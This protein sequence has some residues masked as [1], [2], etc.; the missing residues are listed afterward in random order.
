MGEFEERRRS[1]RVRIAHHGM[2]VATTQRV[3]VLDISLGGVLMASD[4]AAPVSAGRLTV[5]LPAGKMS[6]RVAIAHQ[7]RAADGLIQIGATFVE[8]SSESRRSLEQFLAKTT[9]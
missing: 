2:S 6:S 9:R 8:M 7:L 4:T 5:A 3:R 1:P